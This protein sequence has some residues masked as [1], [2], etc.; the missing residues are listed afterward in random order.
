M[1]SVVETWEIVV[2]ALRRIAVSALVH[3]VKD[4]KVTSATAATTRSVGE[5]VGAGASSGETAP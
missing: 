1:H 4:A 3:E 5:R 2:H